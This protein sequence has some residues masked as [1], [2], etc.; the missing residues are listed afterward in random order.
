M[1][2]RLVES[3]AVLNVYDKHQKSIIQIAYDQQNVNMISTINKFDNLF[4][5][6]ELAKINY[7][8]S[9]MLQKIIKMNKKIIIESMISNP[10]KTL[11]VSNHIVI[12]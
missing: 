11:S 7:N 4:I 12:F 6:K 2:H 5:D 10:Y 3:K 8:G 1:V 9:S